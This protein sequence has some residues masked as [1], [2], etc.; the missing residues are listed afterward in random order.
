MSINKFKFKLEYLLIFSPLL[1][2]LIGLPNS[3]KIIFISQILLIIFFLEFKVNKL[4]LL[5]STIAIFV[6]IF[7]STSIDAIKMYVIIILIFLSFDYMEK[8]KEGASYKKVIYIFIILFSSILF[9]KFTPHTDQY[10]VT[11]TYKYNEEKISNRGKQKVTIQR[12]VFD[13]FNL[14]P[15]H[16]SDIE[17]SEKYTTYNI[18][19]PHFCTQ[20]FYEEGVV[21]KRQNKCNER[22]VLSDTRF[23]VNFVD[24]NFMSIILLTLIFISLTSISKEKKKILLY[25]LLASIIIFLTKSRAGLLFFLISIFMIFYENIK[26]RYI[27][28]LYFLFHILVILFGYI[29]VNSVQDPMFM[30]APSMSSDPLLKIPTYDSYNPLKSEVLRLFSIFDPSNYIRFSSYFQVLLIYLNDFKI[31]L[32]PDHTSLIK[33]INYKTYTGSLFN[34]TSADYDPH[35]LFMALTK[36][37]G[38]IISIYFHFLIFT[39][40]KNPRFR[41]LIVPLIFSSIFIGPPAIYLFPTVLLFSFQ[42]NN[43]YI[44]KKL[45][46]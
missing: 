24:V 31:I 26:S 41:L 7:F 17:K 10:K 43:F 6:I 13:D 44:I 33:E 3:L 36:E 34:V 39:F 32:L 11:Y 30:T 25:F 19:I 18:R 45:I 4:K 15:Y 16:I 27:I 21:I 2:F 46:K 29:M 9:F 28:S 38:L 22:I 40:F 14:D 20:V 37:V 5:S 42:T 35:N 23:T 8:E 1:F 12:E